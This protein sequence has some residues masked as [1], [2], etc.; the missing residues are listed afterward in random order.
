M[1]TLGDTWGS[2]VAGHVSAGPLIRGA[3]SQTRCGCRRPRE[4]HLFIGRT[5]GKV[6]SPGQVDRDQTSRPVIAVTTRA[7][8]FLS[9][10]HKFLLK[11]NISKTPELEIR[12]E[13]EAL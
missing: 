4:P 6:R 1:W 11:R 2:N 12:G 3:D 5:H 7:E 8:I 10:N 13:R 9:Q